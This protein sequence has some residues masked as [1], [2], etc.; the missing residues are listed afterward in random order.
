MGVRLSGNEPLTFA[1]I[2][3]PHLR[4]PGN[5]DYGAYHSEQNM[6]NL[7]HIVERING[8]L[9]YASF[10]AV[11]GDLVGCLFSEN[12]DDYLIG[13]KNPAE[14]FKSIMDELAMPYYVIL[15]NHDYQKGFDPELKEG[16]PTEDPERIEAVWKKV[17]GIEPY[18]S[19][20][21]RGYRFIFL[22]SNRGPARNIVCPR[23]TIEAY[24]TGSFDER[25]LSWL[26]SELAKGDPSLLFVHHPPITDHNNE[27]PWTV[28]GEAYQIHKDDPFYTFVQEYR[29]TIEYIFTGH[30]H[31][32][33]ND[34]LNNTIQVCETGAT[35]DVNGEKDNLHIV[36]VDPKECLID[37]RI[38]N[39]RKKYLGKGEIEELV[40]RYSRER[41]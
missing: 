15:G 38:G 37:V 23:C 5:I 29:N 26:G 20:I 21:D 35:G 13:K 12:T 11:T 28:A 30:G 25:Q 40:R 2:S 8:E 24:C 19:F 14:T 18:Y 39:P 17:L 34:S 22:N 33:I 3:D 10:V 27:K 41:A 7:Q 6:Y 31:M 16:V 1:V 32:W 4:I 36:T 9:S